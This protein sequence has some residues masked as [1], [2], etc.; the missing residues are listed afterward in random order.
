MLFKIGFLLFKGCLEF[1]ECLQDVQST[2]HL[3]GKP[4][5]MTCK[6]SGNPAP[7]LKCELLARDRFLLY[8]LPRRDR[9]G[10]LRP[11]GRFDNLNL[12]NQNKIYR[13]LTRISLYYLH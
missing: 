3:A 8:T 7:Y 5:L 2:P 4:L 6:V 13:R 9:D 12:A 1:T 10:N 11:E